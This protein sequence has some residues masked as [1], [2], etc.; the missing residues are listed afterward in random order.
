MSRIRIVP[1]NRID[2]TFLSRLSACLEER[3]LY[4]CTI[5]QELR[6]PR[7][8]VNSARSQMFASTLLAIVLQNCSADGDVLL[9]V[10]DFD[11]CKTSQRFVFG[12]ADER[13]RVAVVSFHRFRDEFYG[14]PPDENMLFQ[15]TVKE[16]VHELGH[17]LRLG[18]CLNARC[19]MYL[20]NSIFETDN[21]W[22]YFCQP[23]DRRCRARN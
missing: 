17:I 21:K 22:S 1:V 20:S 2:R 19:V 15:R 16:A 4:T 11:L 14:E 18:H 10:T 5:E 6:V 9:A 23:C 7:S 13:Q 12:D 8:S 3:F